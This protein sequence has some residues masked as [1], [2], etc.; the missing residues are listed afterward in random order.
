[1]ETLISRESVIRWVSITM[2]EGN[3][4]PDQSLILSAIMGWL[5]VDCPVYGYAKEIELGNGC[6]TYELVKGE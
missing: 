6:Y 1:M 4:S 3:M 2:K 5:M